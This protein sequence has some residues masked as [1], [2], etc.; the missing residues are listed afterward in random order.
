MVCLGQVLG[1]HGEPGEGVAL[2]KRAHAIATEIGDD[3]SSR[4]RLSASRTCCGG[5][6]SPRRRSDAGSRRRAGARRVGLEVREGICMVKRPRQPRARLLD[7]GGRASR[8]A[9]ARDLSAIPT[10][11]GHHA[12]G[13]VA[14]GRGDS[15]ARSASRGARDGGQ[16]GQLEDHR[17]RSRARPVAASSGRGGERRARRHRREGPI[18]ARASPRSAC[19]PRPIAPSSRARVATTRPNAQPAS[20]QALRPLALATPSIPLGRRS[21]PSRRAPTATPTRPVGGRGRAWPPSRPSPPTR[22]GARPR[23]PLRDAIAS[24]P[25]G[26]CSPRRVG[27]RPWCAG[28]GNPGSTPSRGARGSRSRPRAGDRARAEPAT[29]SATDE[30]GLIAARVRGPRAPRPGP[31]Q[32]SD[33][34]GAVHQRQDGRRPRLAHP[35]QARRRQPR[36][37]GAIA[38]RLGLVP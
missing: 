28:A 26:P 7:A 31:D 37:G 10:A 8:D 14:W 23:R 30:L 4:M 16:R 17:G 25:R 24:R 6:A 36:R 12:A 32:P 3:E 19:E 21:R 27:R 11:Y 5:S 38:H 29:P 22:A 15:T 34:R 35:Q 18:G 20:A 9:L 1:Q 2:L 13:A 33:R